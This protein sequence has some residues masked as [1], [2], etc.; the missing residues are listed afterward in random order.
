MRLLLAVIINLLYAMNVIQ[1]IYSRG[2][3]I[4]ASW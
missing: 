4:T 2:E 1:N 3:N